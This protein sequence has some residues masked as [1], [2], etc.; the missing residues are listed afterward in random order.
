MRR[1]IL[2][3]LVA[4]ATAL[5]LWRGAL[6]FVSDSTRI[7]WRLEEMA[8]AFGDT[9]LRP[10][11]AGLAPDFRERTSELERTLILEILRGFF[12]EHTRGPFPYRVELPE[13]RIAIELDPAGG[14]AVAT[15]V[16]DFLERTGETWEPAW[17]VEIEAELRKTEDGWQLHTSSHQSLTGDVRRLR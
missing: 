13:D 7:R 17:S 11:A 15:F 10:I 6:L 4:L 8:E 5:A 2:I 1:P 12:L 3:A 16:A 14:A 9:R